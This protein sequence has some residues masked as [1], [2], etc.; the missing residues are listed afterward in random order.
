[1]AICRLKFASIASMIVPL[2]G[3]YVLA[4]IQYCPN[5]NMNF[6]IVYPCKALQTL[7]SQ[8]SADDHSA[9]RSA[10]QMKCWRLVARSNNLASICA[11]KDGSSGSGMGKVSLSETP[12]PVF[13]CT[14]TEYCGL[15]DQ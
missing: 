10:S 5:A 14:Y 11:S 1:M 9:R 12:S 15:E 2:D 3:L 4:L 6:T 7:A 8:F 13:P